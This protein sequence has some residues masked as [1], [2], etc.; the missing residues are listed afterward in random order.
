MLT[1]IWQKLKQIIKNLAHIKEMIYDESN[2]SAFSHG[3]AEIQ[4]LLRHF[5]PRKLKADLTFATGDPARTGQL[6]GVICIFPVI[7]RNEVSIVPDFET[8][9]FYIRGTFSVKGRIRLVHAL[10]SGIRI[11]RDKNIR[12][13]IRKIRK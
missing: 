4:Y 13:I 8:D 12:K 5:G 3:C 10:G 6:L 11:W 1:G 2:R 9:D 7:Y